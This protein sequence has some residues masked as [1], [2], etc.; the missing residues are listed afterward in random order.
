[1]SEAAYRKKVQSIPAI[2]RT[3][4]PNNTS[5]LPINATDGV[6]IGEREYCITLGNRIMYGSDFYFLKFV[7]ATVY[8]VMETSFEKK[9]PS[10]QII[11]AESCS[12]WARKSSN[13]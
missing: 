12:A 13:S 3:P 10:E 9:I 5:G 4:F 11:R 7:A 2:L 1:M 6:A 8:W